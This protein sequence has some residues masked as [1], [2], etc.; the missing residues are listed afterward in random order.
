[1]AAAPE[2][3]IR[4]TKRKLEDFAEQVFPILEEFLPGK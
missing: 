3:R 4:E 2:G 1:M